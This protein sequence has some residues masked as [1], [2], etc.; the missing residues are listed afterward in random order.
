MARFGFTALSAPGVLAIGTLAAGIDDSAAVVA[1]P[2]VVAAPPDVVV[3]P[4]VTGVLAA[5]VVALPL[6]SLPQPASRT[7][8]TAATDT[9]ARRRAPC[10]FFKMVPLLGIGHDTARRWCWFGG[11]L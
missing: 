5:A 6:S 3:A 10:C 8:A 7:Q 11:L 1:E 2:A 4:V 9:V